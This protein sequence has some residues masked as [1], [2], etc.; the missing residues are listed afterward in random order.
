MRTY[1][2]DEGRKLVTGAREMVDAVEGRML[3][4]LVLEER[5]RLA[6]T[7]DGC[8]DALEYGEA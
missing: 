3:Y 6:D 5:I 7:L 1:L 8:A 2:T 4:G